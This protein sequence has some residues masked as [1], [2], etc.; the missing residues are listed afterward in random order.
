MQLVSQVIHPQI[1]SSS[2]SSVSRLDVLCGLMSELG[3]CA[4]VDVDEGGFRARM[5]EAPALEG[6]EDAAEVLVY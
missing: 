2:Y 1:S 6:A 4:I 5:V 3:F